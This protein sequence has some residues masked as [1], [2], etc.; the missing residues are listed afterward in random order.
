MVRSI[1]FKEECQRGAYVDVGNDRCPQVDFDGTYVAVTQLTTAS[2]AFR[3]L[4]GSWF[5]CLQR[6]FGGAER[7]FR[8]SAEEIAWRMRRAKRGKRVNREKRGKRRGQV[9]S[10]G[11]E[12]SVR[13]RREGDERKEDERRIPAN[14]F[15]VYVG[16]VDG[17]RTR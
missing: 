3:Q 14:A 16:R 2:P 7:V 4:Y 17:S 11:S 10:E 8:R 13:G 15:G 6:L 9:G 1:D 5:P 12:R